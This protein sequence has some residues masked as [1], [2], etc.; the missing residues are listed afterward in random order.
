MSDSG[1]Q[2]IVVSN[3]KGG[4]G[5]TTTAAIMAQAAKY[6]GLRSLA[7]DMDPQANLSL[8]LAADA[9]KGPGSYGLL[10][11]APAA[12]LIQTTAQGIEV[13]PAAWDLATV[14]SSKASAR[15]L[16]KA[17]EPIK[18]SY[19]LIVIDT[20]STAGELQYNAMQA[21]TGLVIPLV[22]DTYNIQS[23]YQITD[24]ARQIQRT[25]PGLSFTGMLITQYRGRAN[26]AKQARELIIEQA[27]ALGV[28]YLGTVRIGT[29]VQEAAGFRESLFDYAPRSNAAKDYLR[30]FE[31]III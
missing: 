11:G 25:N 16:Q 5:K 31:K 23:L 24:T 12:D 18:D 7:I 3:Q 14:T 21:A 2:I 13:I 28:P 29:A 8:A 6:K 10:T 30:I 15:R 1:G 27:E 9:S 17:L 22:I 20:P 26:F 4:T 19:D